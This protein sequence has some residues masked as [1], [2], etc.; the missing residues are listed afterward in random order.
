MRWV[1]VWSLVQLQRET[2]GIPCQFAKAKK[3]GHVKKPVSIIKSSTPTLLAL[4]E[5]NKKNT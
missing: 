2:A 4:Q 1:V 3:I 5:K